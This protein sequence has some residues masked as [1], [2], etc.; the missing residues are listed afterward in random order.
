[1]KEQD[2]MEAA[3][4]FQKQA[5]LHIQIITGGGSIVPPIT[6]LQQRQAA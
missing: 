6:L 5:E 2:F 3:T 4:F 1:M